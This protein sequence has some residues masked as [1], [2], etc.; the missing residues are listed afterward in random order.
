LSSPPVYDGNSSDA[1]FFCATIND[2]LD[3]A[4]AEDLAG[5]GDITSKAIFSSD[6]TAKALIKS[7]ASGV[8]SGVFL[9][10]PLFAKLDPG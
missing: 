8:L 1:R 5:V 7:K 6:D 3:R 2:L 10:T 4:L 9:L